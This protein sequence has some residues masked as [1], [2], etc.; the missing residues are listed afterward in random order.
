MNTFGNC[1]GDGTVGLKYIIEI[2]S[3]IQ[4]SSFKEI[5]HKGVF[6]AII[7]PKYKIQIFSRFT[8]NLR[9]RAALM[10]LRLAHLFQ[11]VT[12]AISV[13]KLHKV[14]GVGIKEYGT[15]GMR[16]GAGNC[17]NRRKRVPVQIC[18]PQVPHFM[19]RNRCPTASSMAWLLVQCY[20]I[21]NV[22]TAK[23]IIISGVHPYL[24][25]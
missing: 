18:P 6:A 1:L 22:P 21:S 2:N 24:R 5:P 16:V 20:R 4:C 11:F 25:T 9:S 3:F 7:W 17:N 19:I 8:I 23:E 13:S 14:D 12:K 15:V 10:L